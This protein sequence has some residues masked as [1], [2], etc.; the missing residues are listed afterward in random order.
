MTA[1]PHKLAKLTVLLASLALLPAAAQT[2]T[3]AS[4]AADENVTPFQEPPQIRFSGFGTLGGVHVRGNGAAF[5]RDLTQPKGARNQGVSFDI[6]SRLGLQANYPFNDQFE[7]VAQVVSRY[8]HD[9]NYR[10]ELTWGFLKYTPND[11]LEIRAGRVGYDAF[12]GAD[13]R[14]VGYSYLWARPPIEYYGILLFPYIDGGDV[15]LRTP[16]LKGVGRVKLFTGMVRQE[17]SAMMEQREWAGWAGNLNLPP[18]GSV[19]DLNKS[20]ESGIFF[21]YQDNHWTARTGFNQLRITKGFPPGATNMPALFQATAGQA[22]AAGNPALGN[23]LTALVSDLDIVSKK[24]TFKSVELAYENGSLRLQ[25]ALARM[26]SESLVAPTAHTGFFLASYRFGR[27]TPYFT[28]AFIRPKRH[29]QPDQLA[30]LGAPPFIVDM[31]RFSVSGAA[32]R[33]ESYTLGL[34]YELTDTLAL[35]L[36]TDFIRNQ[37]CSPV[38]LP[39]MSP[40]TPCAPPMLWPTVPVGWNGRANVYSA[41]LDFI[42]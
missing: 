13:T 3:P 37:D 42:F 17:A 36:Q 25:G 6:D 16:L 40:G 27:L 38:S 12:I 15:V 34:R 8:N 28:T 10:P 4:P 39:V 7:A 31:T 5:I 1:H 18:I 23:A 9:N 2:S 24:T 11:T 35:K 14:D 26:D 21:E 41:T 32:A 30:Q 22:Y 20:R 33:Q 29:T 19:Q